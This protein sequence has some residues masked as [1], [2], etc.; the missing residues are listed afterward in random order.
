MRFESLTRRGS[1]VLNKNFFKSVKCLAKIGGISQFSVQ[2][3]SKSVK[4]STKMGS[5]S[6][7]CVINITKTKKSVHITM[8][9]SFGVKHNAYWNT[10]QSE[11]K[12][13]D[14][15]K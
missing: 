4:W 9:T 10:I 15:F 3:R 6:H 7:F 13:D 11:V 12:L 14:L 5:I 2:N 1:G 8:V